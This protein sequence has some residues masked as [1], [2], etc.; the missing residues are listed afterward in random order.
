MGERVLL[1]PGTKLGAYE[2]VSLLGAGGMGEV[3]RAKDP[4]LDR[5]VAIKVL[6]KRLARD[7]GAI[8]RFKREAKILAALSHQHILTV[9]A[10]GSE[11]GV[12]Y[13]VSELLEGETLGDRLKRE[14][15]MPWPAV[16]DIALAVADGL[17]AAHSKGIVHRDIKPANLF[18]TKEGVVKV[19]DFGLAKS[20]SQ[21]ASS[22]QA[23]TASIQPR[24]VSATE[25]G[26]VLGTLGYMSPEQAKGVAATPTSDCFSLGCV[27]Y[28][29]L[30]GVAPF[31]RETQ[32]EMLAAI[33]RDDPAPFEPAMPVPRELQRIVR[34]A[35]EKDTDDRFASAVE[36]HQALDAFR[37]GVVDAE[38]GSL[39]GV[40]RRPRLAVPIVAAGALLA[41]FAVNTMRSAARREWAR[42]EALPQVMQWI[43]EREYSMALSLADEAASFIPDDAVLLGLW[44]EMSDTISVETDPPEAD[45]FYRENASETQ[46][47]L[48]GQTPITDHRLPLGGFRLRIEKEGFEPREM[49]SALSYA[50]PGESFEP[51]PSFSTPT[52]RN[53][54]SIRLDPVGSVPA[55]MVAVD[56][57]RYLLPLTSLSAIPVTLDPYFIDR[58]EVTNAEFKEFVDAG[59][60]ERREYWHHEFRRGERVLSWEEAMAEHVDAT[61]RPGPATWE[62]G[63][64]S[65]GQDDY[66]VTGVSWYE[67]AA[68]ASFRGKSLPT[69]HQW[70]RAALPSSEHVMSLAPEIVPLSNFGTDGLAP[71]G[72]FPGIGVSGAVDLAGNAR[73]W[74]WNASGENRLALGGAW[75]D[76]VYAF[77]ELIP[78]DPLDRSPINGFRCMIERDGETAEELKASI[79]LPTFDYSGV[80]G[81]SDEVF[82]AYMDM[83]AYG[84]TPLRPVLE[85]TDETP[86]NW[87]RESISIDTAYGERFTVHLDFPTK[88]SPPYKAVIY[89]PGSNALEQ[90]TFEDAYW[91]RFDYIPKSGRVLVRPVMAE[92]YDRSLDVPPGRV[93][94]R[95]GFQ[96]RTTKWVQDLGRT[97]DYLESRG[98]VDAENVAYMGLSLG[99][100]TAPLM[101]ATEPRF[102]LAVLLAGGL[103]S[104]RT[105]SRMVPRVTV[106]V[107]LLAG[108][109]DYIFPVE[110]R[111]MPLMD[112]L[113]TPEKEKRHVIFEAG[114]LPLPRAEVIRETL[115]WLDRYQGPVVR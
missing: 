38:S 89:F 54:I 6:P 74:C 66:P 96:E 59:G 45:V 15:S 110:T 31:A 25:A 18:V 98:D 56:G 57:G 55:R 58:T 77:T 102:K 19:L 24:P 53:R 36:L 40:L 3:Y 97:I 109:Y 81:L 10:F 52:E 60:Y 4:E 68:Y 65:A 67:A 80:Q 12:G 100:V 95:Q 90:T 43:E 103:S 49:L 111:Q 84:R 63:D 104:G 82:Q 92:M 22:P 114:H 28:E 47:R 7:S 41:F 20:V 51:L 75:S 115:E 88:A 13:A 101:L 91:E 69:L 39:W 78:M 72:S 37:Q 76:P 87:R 108:R 27:L 61:G 46:W 73:E 79:D 107:L 11:G 26:A 70:V 62:V 23:E 71:V 86:G 105:T 17:A 32:T 30:S 48:L 93:M 106:P 99:S 112:L 44:D 16:L 64:Y 1:L 2:I 34:K 42:Q 50:R 35:L 14:D 113:G 29:M 94:T 85:S 9:F 8:Q 33:L 83:F 5:E 21:P